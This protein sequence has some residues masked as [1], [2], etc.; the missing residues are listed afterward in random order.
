[1]PDVVAD[2]LQGRSVHDHWT[3]A[4][5]QSDNQ[6]FY[7]AAFDLIASHLPP[8]THVLDAG[9]GSGTKTAHLVSRGFEV[10]AVDLSTLML[11]EAESALR[12][13]H[14]NAPVRFQQAD[15]TALPFPDG[16]FPAV[17]CW[18]VLMHI[19]S[20][21]KALR[22]LCRVTAPGGVLVISENNVHGLDARIIRL[23][24]K[25]RGRQPGRETRPTAAGEERWEDTPDG[26]MVTRFADPEWIE[27]TAA[28][29]GLTLHS[30]RAGEFTQ[31]YA[32]AP[33]IFRRPMHA[34]NRLWFS[35]VK[36][37]RL[38]LGQFFVFKRCWTLFVNWAGLLSAAAAMV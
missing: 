24:R 15:L 28:A 18:G 22:E 37:P 6:P 38:A 20:V 9:C 25:V 34:L 29:T 23:V 19:P 27:R 7:E 26:Q 2:A 17:V 35:R 12:V 5:R 16:H 4:Y 8:G 36:T 13:S 33:K 30:R 11:A 10:T 32:A 14:P 31:L 3:A 1:M 21:E